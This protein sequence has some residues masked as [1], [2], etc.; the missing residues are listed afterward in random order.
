[1]STSFTS[2]LEALAF[3]PGNVLMLALVALALRGT[4][5]RS[6]FAVA[7]GLLYVQS[8]PAV[9]H[10]FTAHLERY[11]ALTLDR[12]PAADAI[13]VLAGGRYPDAPEYGGD[14][15]SDDS[16]ERLRYAADLERASR[17]PLVITGGNRDGE[18]NPEALLMAA[19]LRDTFGVGS[20]ILTE[21]RSRTTAENALY[22]KSLLDEHGWRR[23]LLV[24]HARHMPRSLSVFEKAGV[25]VI[26][27]PMHY[28]AARGGP[29]SLGAWLP[30]AHT[31]DQFREA[32]HEYVGMLWY[33]VRY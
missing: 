6:V 15:I 19:V 9:V 27:A 5:R 31:M 22:T 21:T 12:L 10:V 17:L 2:I 18:P 1:M 7:L 20:E 32:C 29:T 16:L 33:R 24:T 3:P 23:V 11:P 30:Q 26:A 8:V 4:W 13:V 25:D 28:E 14:S